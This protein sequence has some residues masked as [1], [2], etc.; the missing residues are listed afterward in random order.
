MKT[1]RPK[2]SQNA[3]AR[4]LGLS[5]ASVTK[6]KNMGM[7]VD[8]VEAAIRWRNQNLRHDQ[9]TRPAPNLPDTSTRQEV[10]ALALLALNALQLGEFA[11]IAPRMRA[12]LRAL[13]AHDREQVGL[14]VEVWDA[15]T[16]HVGTAIT[17]GGDL[18]PVA[19]DDA[20]AA[21]M[22]AFWFEVASGCPA[23]VP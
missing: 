9:R 2:L 19:L 1:N 13:P 3:L 14:P 5:A 11:L 6:N 23:E 15:L 17:R 8:S 12:T 18:Q 22:G 10:E 21:R 4:A 20:Q 7:P 16:N